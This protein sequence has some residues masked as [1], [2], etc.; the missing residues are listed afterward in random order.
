MQEF[1]IVF[2]DRFSSV[3]F[4]LIFARVLMSWFRPNRAN[5]LV[6]FVYDTT[7]PMFDLIYS[8]MPFVRRSMIDF[9]PIVALLAVDVLRYVLI[10]MVMMI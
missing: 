6:K 7:Q 3:L 8:L 4:I 10:Y 5:V 1:L 2:I 9:S